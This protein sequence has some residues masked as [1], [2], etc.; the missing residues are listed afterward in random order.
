MYLGMVLRKSLPLDVVDTLLVGLAMVKFGD[1][2]AHGIVR[3]KLGPMQFKAL[4]GKT[5]VIDVG[6]ISKIRSGEIKV[7]V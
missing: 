4:T 5:P 7:I 2:S 3:P 6:T 1:L